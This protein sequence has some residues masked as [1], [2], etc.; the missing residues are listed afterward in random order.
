M[1]ASAH[2]ANAREALKGNWVN[3]VV[4]AFLVN[5]IG[6]AAGT[7]LNINLNLEGGQ[8]V[9]FTAPE[10][11]RTLLQML[12]LALPLILTLS[13]IML[14]VSMILGGV[15]EYGSARYNL[16]LIDRHPAEIS[17]LFT[18]IPRFADALVMHLVRNV[19]ILLGFCLLIVPGV[20][21]TY[22][23]AMAP[24]ILAEDDSCTGLD[25]LKRS[26]ELMKGNKVDLFV[27]EISF[28]GWSIL[29]SFTAGLGYLLLN[30][31][32][33]AAR[34]SFYRDLHWGPNRG[35]EF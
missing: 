33:A 17:D 22:G 18:G 5:V 4:V 34:A 8:I 12:G 32:T 27:L 24:Y 14:V 15:L 9:E 11:M 6:N 26:W 10:Q 30:P 29:A 28:I 31:Y 16:N 3:A 20:M 19:L 13:G 21:L 35:P 7:R 2:R 25:A 23:F 1:E